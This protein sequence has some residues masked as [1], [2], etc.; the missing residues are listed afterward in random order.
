MSIGLNR[1]YPNP[2]NPVTN[3]NYSLPKMANVSL[4]VYDMTGREIVALYNGTQT[5]GYHTI[6][7]NASEQS[8]GIYFVKMNAGRYIST[9]KLM[10]IK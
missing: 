2:F 8:S 5:P 6:N 10:L 4:T 9:Q 7:W 3:I 1:S